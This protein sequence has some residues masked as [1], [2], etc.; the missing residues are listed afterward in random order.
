[1][2]KPTVDDL[3][4]TKLAGNEYDISSFLTGGRVATIHSFDLWRHG[5]ITYALIPSYRAGIDDALIR[6]AVKAFK[7]KP[8]DHRKRC[9]AVAKS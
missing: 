1:M 2:P 4:V 5:L 7:E 3:I 8:H 9:A 6:K